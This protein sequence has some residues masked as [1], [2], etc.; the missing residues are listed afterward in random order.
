MGRRTKRTLQRLEKK[1]GVNKKATTPVYCGP[2]PDDIFDC[3]ENRR[4]IGKILMDS[5]T[6]F[7]ILPGGAG[8]PTGVFS[9]GLFKGN[10]HKFSQF[11]TEI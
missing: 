9:L 1:V 2:L 4:T 11:G 10:R 7:L 3:V 6:P 8:Y 5:Q